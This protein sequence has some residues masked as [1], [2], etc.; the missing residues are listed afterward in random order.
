MNF[1]NAQLCE[2]NGTCEEDDG[3]Y[4]CHCKDGY[5]GRRCHLLPC[6]YKRCESYEICENLVSNNT[7]RDSYK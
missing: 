1:C 2:H 3:T 6:D 5:I 4:K 7:T